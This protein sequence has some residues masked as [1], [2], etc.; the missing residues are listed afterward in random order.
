MD[1]IEEKVKRRILIDKQI[2]ILR[3]EQ[4]EIDKELQFD[5]MEKDSKGYIDTFVVEGES[6]T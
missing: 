6:Y 2:Q 4:Y 5:L 1:S 3:L